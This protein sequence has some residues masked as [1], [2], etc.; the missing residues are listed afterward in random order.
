[1]GL[2][3]PSEVD[4][5]YRNHSVFGSLKTRLEQVVEKLGKMRSG[6]QEDSVGSAVPNTQAEKEKVS[7]AIGVQSGVTQTVNKNN[8][9][10]GLSKEE[11][12]S[13][14]VLFLVCVRWHAFFFSL[15]RVISNLIF[16][17]S[18]SDF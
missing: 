3:S 6:R 5:I 2:S 8:D 17:S 7:E 4:D 11:G 14:W 10:M 16:F 18:L 12:S 1:M 9:H 13:E 15:S